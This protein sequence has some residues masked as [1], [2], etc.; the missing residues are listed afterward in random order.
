MAQLAFRTADRLRRAT[1]LHSLIA[2]R[3]MAMTQLDR[4]GARLRGGTA[5][6]GRRTGFLG[7]YTRQFQLPRP[8][9]LGPT[10]RLLTH[11]GATGTASTSPNRA[12]NLIWHGC[13]TLTKATLGHRMG[14]EN[15]Q[16]QAGEPHSGARWAVH[17]RG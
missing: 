12:T 8:D 5:V 3:L 1:A 2:G 4:P 15:A 14:W 6:H 13:D 9:R 11:L 10:A 17:P 16:R 7:D